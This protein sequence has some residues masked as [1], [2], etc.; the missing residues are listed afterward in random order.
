[1]RFLGWADDIITMFGFAKDDT[2]VPKSGMFSLP[3]KY[4]DWCKCGIYMH[5]LVNTVV[6]RYLFFAEL[7][8][9][10]ITVVLQYSSFFM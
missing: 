4:R 10:G 1:M 6:L 2:T 3:V 5:V 9:L 8:I 7:G